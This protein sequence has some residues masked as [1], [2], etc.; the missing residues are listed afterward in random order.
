MKILTDVEQDR[1]TVQQLEHFDKTGE[2]S[3]IPLIGFDQT[4]K[5]IGMKQR[6]DG[7]NFPRKLTRKISRLKLPEDVLITTNELGQKTLHGSFVCLVSRI[8]VSNGAQEACQV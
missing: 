3:G 1:Q 7:L 5:W 6:T 4:G 2:L 8:C